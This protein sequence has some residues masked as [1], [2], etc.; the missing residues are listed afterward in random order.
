M[1]SI[2]IPNTENQYLYNIYTEEREGLGG[3][4]PCHKVYTSAYPTGTNVNN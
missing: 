3:I 1:L 2:Q 4:Y